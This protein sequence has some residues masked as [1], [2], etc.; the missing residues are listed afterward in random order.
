MIWPLSL[1][2]KKV[3]P[4]KAHLIAPAYAKVGEL[5]HFDGTASTGDIANWRFGLDAAEGVTAWGPG[6]VFA[7][8]RYTKPGNYII[9]L[10][11]IGPTALVTEVPHF[12]T[13]TEP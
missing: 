6:R 2:Q 13:V 10:V 7:A 4:P 9:S 1:L 5:V 8:Y 3:I 12:L 11:L